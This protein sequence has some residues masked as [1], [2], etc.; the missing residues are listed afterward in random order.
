MVICGQVSACGRSSTVFGNLHQ[1][2]I[3]IF[4]LLQDREVGL[5][6]GLRARRRGFR[7]GVAPLFTALAWVLLLLGLG[8]PH[9]RAQEGCKSGSP[10][11]S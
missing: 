10:H 11:I 2:M 4:G 1:K 6:R 7:P 9:P 5:P 8:V 3:F